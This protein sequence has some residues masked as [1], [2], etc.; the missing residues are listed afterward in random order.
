MNILAKTRQFYPFCPA[1]YLLFT[2]V[3]LPVK[4]DFTGNPVNRFYRVL[5]IITSKNSHHYLQGAH[6]DLHQGGNH[7]EVPAPAIK[8]SLTDWYLTN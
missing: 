3:M 7:A 2:K 8:Q 4:N 6:T 1:F 5:P